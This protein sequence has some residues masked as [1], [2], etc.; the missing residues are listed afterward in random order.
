MRKSLLAIAATCLA[1]L[2]CGGSSS[3][4]TSSNIITVSGTVSDLGG[5][6]TFPSGVTVAVLDSLHSLQGSVQIIA[7]TT[8]DTSGNFTLT[9][10]DV[11]NQLALVLLTDDAP[12][13]GTSYTYVAATAVGGTYFPTITGVAAYV[14]TANAP[15][16]EKTDI[17]DTKPFLLPNSLVNAWTTLQG[18]QGQPAPL[19]NI[20]STGFAL[21]MV[22]DSNQNPI[23][24]ATVSNTNKSTLPIYYLPDGGNALLSQTSDKGFF[25]TD[26]AGLPAV[27][28]GTIDEGDFTVTATPT[29]TGYANCIPVPALVLSQLAYIAIIKCQH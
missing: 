7:S 28:L 27:N 3:P 9:K 24:G 16:S 5:A 29:P 25:I 13:S 11:T 17:S 21:G 6:T 23:S 8:S 22:V 2:G 26:D 18:P 15:K 12:S 20:E 4:A 14:T 19:S 10:V 1:I